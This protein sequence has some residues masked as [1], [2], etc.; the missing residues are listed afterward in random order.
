M[1]LWARRYLTGPDHHGGATGAM[2]IAPPMVHPTQLE[3]EHDGSGGLL[4]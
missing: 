3:T 2:W 1:A 4:E